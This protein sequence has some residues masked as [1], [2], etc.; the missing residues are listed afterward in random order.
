MSNHRWT[1][2]IL[3]VLLA[4]GMLACSISTG[5]PTKPTAEILSPP[6]GSQVALGEEV[7][8]EYRASDPVAVVRV[9]LEADGEVV[10]AQ[11]SPLAEGQP[12]MTGILRWT[13]TTPGTHTLVVYAYN[14]DRVVSDAVGVSIIAVEGPEPTTAPAPPAATHTVAPPTPVPPTPT[15]TLPAPS[16]TARDGVALIVLAN[17]SGLT[18]SFVGIA[19]PE[20]TDWGDN[21]LPNPLPDG[22]THTFEVAPGTYD[23]AAMDTNERMISQRDRVTVSGTFNW[24][25]QRLSATLTLHNNSGVEVWYAYFALSTE[26]S[27]GEDRLYKHR[28][29]DG[30][31]YAW[32]VFPGTYD[33]RATDRDRNVLD[34]RRGVS[35]TATHDWR[36]TAAGGPTIECPT[37]T[38]NVPSDAPPRRVFGIEWDSTAPLPSGWEYALQYSADQDSWTRLPVPLDP[39]WYEEGG[40]FKA[41]IRGPGVEGTFYWQVCLVNMADPTG[42]SECCGPAH[43]IIHRR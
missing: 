30:G 31:S 8:V 12:S 36:I 15:H 39:Y 23:L 7:E 4:L 14:R 33:L 20:D 35:I 42:P 19:L 37:L 18:V 26:D 32:P 11:N 43:T 6:S 10:D 24:T 29:P 40:H 41:V 1:F 25:I 17:N 9:E 22:G 28:V 21:R 34:D 16:P 38:I 2:V 3:I 13:P 5:G 27:W